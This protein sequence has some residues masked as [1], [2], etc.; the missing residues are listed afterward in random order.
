L[1]GLVELVVVVLGELAQGLLE[2]PIQVVAEAVVD[3]T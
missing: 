3:L 2:Q 1:A